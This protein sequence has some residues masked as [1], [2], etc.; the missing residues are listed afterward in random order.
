MKVLGKGRM[1]LIVCAAVG[2]ALLC[3]AQT[4]TTDRTEFIARALVCA[5]RAATN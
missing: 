3:A 4:A 1:A 5:D 2:L